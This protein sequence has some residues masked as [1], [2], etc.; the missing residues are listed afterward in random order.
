MYH[1]KFLCTYHFYDEELRKLLPACEITPNIL[2]SIEN[3]H[4]FADILYK[5]EL[6]QVFGLNEIDDGEIAKE[7]EMMYEK[8]K[9]NETFNKCILLS[10]NKMMTQ[11]PIFGLMVMFNYH[12]FFVTHRC[13]SEFIEKGELSNENEKLLVSV[14]E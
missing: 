8:V 6:L 10:A 12:T 14:F 1:S 4:D 2:E 5:A 11:D 13:L 3:N 9:T 7:M